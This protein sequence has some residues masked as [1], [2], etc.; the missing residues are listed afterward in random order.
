MRAWVAHSIIGVTA[1]ANQARTHELVLHVEVITP[2]FLHQA[3]V[4]EGGCALLNQIF[5]GP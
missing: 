1:A 2:P 5:S 3:L 4:A